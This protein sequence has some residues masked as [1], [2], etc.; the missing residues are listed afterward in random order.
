[1]KPGSM[2]EGIF[3]DVATP[4]DKE[5]VQKLYQKRNF[6]SAEQVAVRRIREKWVEL[7]NSNYA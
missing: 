5:T 1:M 7:L 2:L 6:G 4:E 3:L